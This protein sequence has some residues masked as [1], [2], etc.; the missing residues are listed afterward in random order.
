VDRGQRTNSRQH[1]TQRELIGVMDAVWQQVAE[2]QFFLSPIDELS[3][4]RP[5][6]KEEL[7]RLAG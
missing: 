1:A 7:L 2:F 5:D 4:P 6:R 3:N